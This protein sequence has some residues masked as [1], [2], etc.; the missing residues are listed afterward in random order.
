M[1]SSFGP[2]ADGHIS[3]NH[4]DGIGLL[5]IRRDSRRNALHWPLWVE[6]GEKVDEARDLGLRALILTGHGAHFCSGMDLKPDNPL[7]HRILPAIIDADADAARGV[8]L[9]L[10]A[11]TRK[12]LDF[13]APTI[14]AIE[15]VCAGG[16]YEVALHCDMLVIGEGG[17]V[18]LPEVRW[19][20]VP[21]V[22]GT[23]LLTRRVGPGRA[24][25]AVT[26]GRMF[27][28]RRA[29]EL[30]YVDVVCDE[31][32]ALTEA[33][34]IATDICE[35]GPHAVGAAVAAL[36]K[37]PGRSLD[38]ALSAETDA[39]VAALTSGEPREGTMAF[40]EKRPASWSI[41]K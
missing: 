15:G 29:L 2:P 20:M 6:L 33:W 41:Q 11:I 28:A 39:G 8:I 1:P 25:L 16:G 3:L 32:T 34:G 5:T 12:L 24:A 19:G 30:G 37:V 4:Q 38:A 26:T 7:V 21:D 27:D 23:T 9:E 35:G 18:G 22:G 14:A 40:A 36:R 31:G 13:P 17:K 10:K